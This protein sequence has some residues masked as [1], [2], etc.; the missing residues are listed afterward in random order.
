MNAHLVIDSSGYLFTD[1]LC[2]L[3]ANKLKECSVEQVCVKCVRQS[4]GHCSVYEL[5]FSVYLM[6]TVAGEHAADGHGD[7]P[8]SAGCPRTPSTPHGAPDC[9]EGRDRNMS[10]L[11]DVV[12]F[13]K[14]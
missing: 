3:I 5:T 1:S 10:V 12:M 13:V 4:T 8:Q 6:L 14:H 7:A 2:T 11:Q 9:P